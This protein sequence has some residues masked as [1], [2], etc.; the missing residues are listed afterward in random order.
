MKITII[1]AGVAGL[2]AALELSAHGLQVEIVERGTRLGLFA[3]SML[4]GGLISPWCEHETLEPAVTQMGITSLKWWDAHFA[5]LVKKGSLVVAPSRD[6]GELMRFAA[7]TRNYSWLSNREIAEVEPDLAGQFSKALFF[8]EEAHLDPRAA[9]ADLAAQLKSRGVAIR[10]G[11]DG[12]PLVASAQSGNDIVIDCRGLGARDR[13]KD[14]RGVRGEM[15]VVKSADIRIDR[16]VRLLHPRFP[17]YIV[18]RGNGVY[19]L[20]ATSIESESK[21]KITTRSA[22]ELLNAAYTLHPG[23]AEA[24]ILETGADLRPAF[25]D[26]LPR[27]TREGNLISI[28]GLYRHGFLAA[29]ALAQEAATLIIG[30]TGEKDEDL[31]QRHLA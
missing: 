19:M 9:L 28:N 11:V 7:R 31:R 12:A 24:E 16:P 14:L 26:N 13:L 17:L 18:P 2:T 21:S 8:P 25:A 4:A 22:V 23:F 20:G 27:I 3:C 6:E 29:P 30:T 10:F 1:G 15:M 5:G